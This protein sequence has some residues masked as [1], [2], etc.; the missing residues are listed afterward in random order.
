MGSAKKKRRE[1]PK[2]KVVDKVRFNLYYG[3]PYRDRAQIHAQELRTKGWLV[4]IIKK[5]FPD[6]WWFAL[7]R[8]KK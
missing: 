8:R 2:T 3:H 6:G 4:R 5:K 7:Y 1:F